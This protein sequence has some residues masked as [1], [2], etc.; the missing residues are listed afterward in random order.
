MWLVAS[1]LGILAVATR[2][3]PWSGAVDVTARVAPVLIF[4]V[5]VTV[6]AELADQ[7]QV[8]DA[9]AVRAARLA[10]GNVHRLFLLVLALGT[11]TTIV[12]SL[13]TTAVLLTPVVLSLATQLE[14]EPLPFAF[15]A[16][17]LANTASLLLPVSNLTN[18]LAVDRLHVAPTHYL[19]MVALPAL[20][21]VGVTWVAL[22]W[23]HRRRLRGCYDPPPLTAVRDRPLFL[24]AVAACGL[25]V[26]ALLLG[27]PVATAASASALLLV[28]A[29]V[30][31]RRAELR[32]SLVPWRLVMMVEGLFLVVSALGP[33]GLDVAL[34]DAAG[35]GGL[36]T[37]AAAAIG[38][39]LVNNL[40]AYLALERVV[41]SRGLLD[42]LIGVNVGPLVLPWG[43]L[44]TLLWIERCRA[45]GLEVRMRQFA[46]AGLAFVPVLLVT[47][48]LAR[49]V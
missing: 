18:L 43:S 4:L 9:A 37:A 49:Y 36:R 27:I 13:D 5:A 39:N 32:W 38:A 22:L 14:L 24:V 12:L 17:W 15:A 42:V 34:R 23:W 11:V 8:F 46:L 26:P 29:F 33:H 48:V 3:L 44:A 1:A 2:L 6:L 41:P 28:L 19:A 31:R 45:R 30:L 47:T 7:A 40:P 16:V 35:H 21:A 20:T 10:R 25:L